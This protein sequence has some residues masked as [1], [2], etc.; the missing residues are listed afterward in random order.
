[1]NGWL[2]RLRSVLVGG[3][4]TKPSRGITTIIP[5]IHYSTRSASALV[6]KSG[7]KLASCYSAINI[8]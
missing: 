3:K 6:P 2:W 5:S 8:F 1:M 7:G 4:G